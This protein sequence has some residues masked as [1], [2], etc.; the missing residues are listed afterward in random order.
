MSVLNS[1]FL[2]LL[3]RSVKMPGSGTLGICQ[4]RQHPQG[5]GAFSSEADTEH[6]FVHAKYMFF[7]KVYP[8][9]IPHLAL[10]CS[11]GWP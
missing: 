5:M 6:G 7:C 11:S 1:T 8:A 4:R 2:G 10:L 3:Y 9:N